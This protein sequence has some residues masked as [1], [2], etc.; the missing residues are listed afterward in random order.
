MINRK[1][2]LDKLILFAF[3]MIP[4]VLMAALCWFAGY[5]FYR[6]EYNKTHNHTIECTIIQSKSVVVGT[7]RAPRSVLVTTKDCGDIYISRTINGKSQEDAVR[8]L[9]RERRVK[10]TIGNMPISHEHTYANMYTIVGY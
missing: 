2:I 8:E 7:L 10:F 9:I 4:A 1:K 6:Y 5:P 3:L